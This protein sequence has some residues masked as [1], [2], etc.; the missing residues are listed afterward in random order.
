[1]I[2]CHNEIQDELVHLAGKVLTHSVIRNE[3]LIHPCC[4]SEKLNNC[5]TNHA[6]K[7]PASEDD[8]EDILLPILWA[9]GTDCIVNIRVTDTDAKSYHQHDPAKAI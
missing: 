6:N 1:M 4:V 7:M 2:F 8:R 5:P 3:P 9:C